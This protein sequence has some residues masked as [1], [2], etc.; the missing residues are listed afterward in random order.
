MKTSSKMRFAAVPIALALVAAACGGDDDSTTTTAAPSDSTEAP[1]EGGGVLADICPSPLVIQ[2]DW[3]PESEHG[4]LYEMVGDDYVVDTEKLTVTGSLVASG[5]VDT[6]IE[7]QVRT[8]GPAIGFSPVSSTM[9]TDTS[10]H[11]GYVS[12][13]DA[14]LSFADI[15][16]LAVVAP[17]EI[18]PQIIMWDPE[19]YPD[20]EGIADLGEQGVTMNVFA[21]GT[22]L[23]VFV[24]EGVVSRDQI[25]PSYD[26]SPARWVAEAGKIAQQG[27]ASAEPY[28]YK[29][30]FAEWGKDVKYELVHDAGFE[31]YAAPLAI[32]AGDLETLRPCLEKFVPIAQQAA[33]D[34]IN[35]GAR[36]IDII[37]DA[38]AKFDSFWVYGEGVAEYS[39]QTMLELGLVGNGP[40]STL[41][42]FDFDRGN[43][44]L[45]Q[46]KDAGLSVPA[47]ITA[48][49]IMTNEFVDTSI[50]L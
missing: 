34:F 5:G 22:Y 32:R 21:G 42:N 30:E 13:D 41:G 3:F 12:T 4:A 14:A 44:V 28:Q 24:A 11:M 2:T 8:G 27:F 20:V 17:L 45:Q 6:G 25:D 38:V 47:D 15:P 49:Q 37:I 40:D 16:T 18:N 50:G 23:E 31:L 39:K 36:A 10:I 35:D 26:G 46:M 7:I 29:N 43:T 48:E 33:I 1:S 9:A 19:T